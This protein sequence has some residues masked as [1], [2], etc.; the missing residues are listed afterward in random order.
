MPVPPIVASFY[1]L[2][3]HRPFEHPGPSP[4]DMRLRIE[5]AA[6]AGYSGIGTDCVDLAHA[7]ETHGHAGIKAMLADNGLSFFELEGIG[8]WYASGPA[9]EAS[10]RQRRD[11]LV[12]AEKIGL[13]QIKLTGAVFMNSV[14]ADVMRVEFDRFCR[15]AADA[16]TRASLEMVSIS[17]IC[18]LETA[19]FVIGDTASRNGGLCADIWHF[20]RGGVPFS[21]LA[22]VPAGTIG[23]VE[24]DDGAAKPVGSIISEQLDDRRLPGEGAFDIAGFLSAVRAAGYDGGY[25]VEILSRELRA[26]PLA[27][28]ARRSY[29]Q[30]AKQFA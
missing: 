12:A 16:G 29:Q 27:D 24:L 2:A 3:G 4:Y 21:E 5:A 9:R 22:A 28:A 11:M 6:A 18:D 19:L 25:G 10:D 23:W 20:V 30:A 13:S 26:L 15:E 8:D 7:V 1:T 17:D 14:P